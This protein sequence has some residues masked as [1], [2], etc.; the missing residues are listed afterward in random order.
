MVGGARS[1]QFPYVR[2][3]LLFVRRMV[4]YILGLYYTRHLLG[5]NGGVYPHCETKPGRILCMA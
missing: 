4:T 2:T 5:G 3:E 1:M